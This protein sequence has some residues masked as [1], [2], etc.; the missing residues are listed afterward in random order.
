MSWSKARLFIC[1]AV[2]EKHKYPKAEFTERKTVGEE[3]VPMT[4]E[5]IV[6]WLYVS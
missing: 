6:V 2:T 5:F 3:L 4:A 1:Q